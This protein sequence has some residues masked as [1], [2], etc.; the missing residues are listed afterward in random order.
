[1]TLRLRG[2]GPG[3]T[4]L[5]GSQ[6]CRLEKDATKKYPG[7]EEFKEEGRNFPLGEISARLENFRRLGHLFAWWNSHSTV[8][9]IF[10]FIMA[11]LEFSRVTIYD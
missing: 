2:C 8:R 1:M 9:N 5:V 7:V 3:V 11:I 10:I 6:S 4:S